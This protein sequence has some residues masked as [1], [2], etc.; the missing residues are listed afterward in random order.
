MPTI[1]CPD[2]NRELAVKK[3]LNCKYFKP[4]FVLLHCNYKRTGTG[5]CASKV[6]KTRKEGDYCTLW[7]ERR[8]E[9]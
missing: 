7:D 6:P 9:Q 2:C 3:C 1:V 4:H 8:I 5:L